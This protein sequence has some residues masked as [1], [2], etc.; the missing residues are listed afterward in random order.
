MDSIS[1]SFMS[2]SDI[3]IAPLDSFD[4]N[5]A[6]NAKDTVKEFILEVNK[7]DYKIYDNLSKKYL[8]YSDDYDIMETT[9][10]GV[11]KEKYLK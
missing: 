2:N 1:L 10:F 8:S 11:F 6:A 5:C 9:R 4:L 3:R 7:E